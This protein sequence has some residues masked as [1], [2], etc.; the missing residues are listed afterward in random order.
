M[1]QF[2]FISIFRFLVVGIG[3]T[4]IGLGLIYA[5]LRLGAGDFG[6]NAFGY[7]VGLIFSFFFN[8]AWTFSHSGPIWQSAWRFAL[9][10]AFAYA[11]NLIT[12]FTLLA[13]MGKEAFVAHV[14]GMVPYSTIS[15]L[16]SRFFVFDHARLA[17]NPSIE[18][19]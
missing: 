2:T 3:N 6:A 10:F 8:R 14:A 18:I 13:T 19:D 1:N 9:V 7:G 15:F 11:A 5:C 16:G 4:L 12:T 17:E